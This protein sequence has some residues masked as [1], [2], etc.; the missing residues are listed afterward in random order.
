[1][2][3]TGMLTTTGV[4]A[5]VLSVIFALASFANARRRRRDKERGH[6]MVLKMKDT[7]PSPTRI[8]VTDLYATPSDA[9]VS[10]VPPP[11]PDP[12]RPVPHA[13]APMVAS[14]PA[15]EPVVPSAPPIP[16]FKQLVPRGGIRHPPI[17][18]P[19]AAPE[20]PDQYTWE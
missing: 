12:R 2:D 3:D 19:G 16:V 10:S 6:A 7:E 15:P 14:P 13:S 11:P 9:A 17:S 20:E 1:M 5:T 18:T 4:V 8:V